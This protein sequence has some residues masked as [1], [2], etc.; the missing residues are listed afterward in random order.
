MCQPSPSQDLGRWKA[1]QLSAASKENGD[2]C[3]E[4]PAS[5][6]CGLNSGDSGSLLPFCPSLS[7]L[8]SPLISPPQCSLETTYLYVGIHSVR[9]SCVFL[10]IIHTICLDSFILATSDWPMCQASVILASST[11]LSCKSSSQLTYQQSTPWEEQDIESSLLTL[12]M[13]STT[14]TLG[15]W[16]GL[17]K[18]LQWGGGSSLLSSF[19]GAA[20]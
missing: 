7:R 10:E 1:V 16:E 11:A 13:L 19:S 18:K 14:L 20:N 8:T 6:A 12:Q 5:L 3:A 15:E 4:F 2:S 9:Y 17:I